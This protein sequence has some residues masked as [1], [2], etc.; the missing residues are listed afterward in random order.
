[1][2][3]NV[4]PGLIYVGTTFVELIRIHLGGG[5]WSR[6]AAWAC[7]RWCTEA[8]W[9]RMRLRLGDLA[10]RKRLGEWYPMTDTRDFI[11]GIARVSR[12]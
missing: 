8:G 9:P 12:L 7:G 3:H 1:M 10:R 4:F 11:R 6:R 2:V 5:R